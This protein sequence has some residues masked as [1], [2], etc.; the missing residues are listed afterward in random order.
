M[1]F[2]LVSSGFGNVFDI[3]IYFHTCFTDQGREHEAKGN[4]RFGNDTFF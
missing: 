2:A 4:P 1:K 3:Y